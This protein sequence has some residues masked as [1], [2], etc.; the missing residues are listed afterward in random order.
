MKLNIVPARTGIQWVKLGIQTF[1][2]QPLAMTGLFFMY[3]AL[4]SL[5]LLLPLVGPFL[6]LAVVP[7]GTLGFMAA[8][9]EAERGKFP[10]PTLLFSAF[11]AGR[12]RVRAMLV[13]GT[14]YTATCLAMVLLVAMLVD[15]PPSATTPTEL[16]NSKEFR[17]MVLLVLAFYTPISLAFWHAPALVH[18]DGH[19]CAKALFSSTIAVWRNRG[20]FA[21]H[22]LI[23]FAWIMGL[24]MLGGLLLS[25]LGQPQL[26]LTI[27][28]PISAVVAV[29]YYASL[30][31]TFADCFVA[32][33][34]DAA[35][36]ALPP[37]SET[38]PS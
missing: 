28:L 35:G 16:A 24:G 27:T 23:W 21:M 3:S 12:D 38:T 17:T 31:F 2:K 32:T 14:L 37:P 33:D 10:A 29:V 5:L 20:A 15:L 1:K 19:G 8:T 26:L 9:Q 11:K 13:L 34:G 22:S 30:Y 36:G 7:A 18:W 25:V 4:A 6:M